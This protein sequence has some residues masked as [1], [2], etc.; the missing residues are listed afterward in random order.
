MRPKSND[1]AEGNVANQE[2]VLID[3]FYEDLEALDKA[4]GAII[5]DPATTERY[6]WRDPATYVQREIW[7]P[8]TSSN[9]PPSYNFC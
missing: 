6:F 1:Q 3:P 5:Q 4:Q 7:R 8:G 2:Q 9:N